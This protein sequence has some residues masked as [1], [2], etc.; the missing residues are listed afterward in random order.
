M[1]FRSLLIGAFAALTSATQAG[2][3]A[4]YQSDSSFVDVMDGLKP[5]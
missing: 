5:R 4:V 2:G 1:R 3:Y